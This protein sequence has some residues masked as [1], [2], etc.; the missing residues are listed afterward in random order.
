M[1][2]R[3]S[4]VI[5]REPAAVF[6]YVTDPAKDLSWRSFLT[7]SHGPRPLAAGSIVR[8]TYS[9]QGHAVS[10]ELEVTAYEAPERIELKAQGRYP[11]RFVLT[12]EP[13][14]GG[15][16]FSMSGTLQLSGLAA[17]FEGRVQREA[18]AAVAGDLKRL[19]AALER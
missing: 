10:V 14:G 1:H 6:A 3:G 17:M 18:D 9:Y 12:C 19:K 4:I 13:E 8:Q 11:A 16:R 2:T 15:T 7:A 5:E